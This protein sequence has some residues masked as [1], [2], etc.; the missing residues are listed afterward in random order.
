MKYA[1]N[2]FAGGD[3]LTCSNHVATPLNYRVRT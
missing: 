2:T 3:V 1:K